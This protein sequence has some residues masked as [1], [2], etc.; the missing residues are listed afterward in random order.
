MYFNYTIS[1]YVLHKWNILRQK[2]K[3]IPWPPSLLSFLLSH[4][5]FCKLD[6]T[7]TR[8]TINIRRNHWQRFANN[9]HWI[10][11]P[12]SVAISMV[13]Q[14]NESLWQLPLSNRHCILYIMVIELSGVQF[15]FKPYTWFQ[16][17]TS[18]Q[19]EFDLKSQI[20]FQTKFHDPMFTCY[21]ITFILN[22]TIS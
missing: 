3:I 15:G 13:C 14:T 10:L 8:T 9:E 21:F 11:C 16:N 1:S 20:W 12:L 5:T 19:R 4:Q 7:R 6:A 18:A 17:W 22:H 2:C